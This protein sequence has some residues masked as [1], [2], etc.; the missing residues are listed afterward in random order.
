MNKGKSKFGKDKILGFLS[1]VFLLLEIYGIY[2]FIRQGSFGSVLDYI[3]LVVFCYATYKTLI[4]KEKLKK[5]E[6]Y[7]VII[8]IIIVILGALV[9]LLLPY[10]FQTLS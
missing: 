8:S 9:G 10:T 4:R 5:W 6:V 3:F 7:L 1:L 2:F